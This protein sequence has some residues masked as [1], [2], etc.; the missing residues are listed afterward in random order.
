MHE[1]TWDRLIR[2]VA[3]PKGP[4]RVLLRIL[5][6]L[7][8]PVRLL[9]DAW[10]RR[11]P[12]DEMEETRDLM[13]ARVA[14]ALG[15]DHRLTLHAKVKHAQTLYRMGEY[16]MAEAKL[17]DVIARLASTTPD[18]P[19]LVNARGWRA[20]ALARLGRLPEA[21]A[22]LRWLRE[23]KARALGPDHPETL[24]YQNL[25]GAALYQTGRRD[26]ARREWDDVR[27]RKASA[28]LSGRVPRHVPKDGGSTI[29][30][31]DDQDVA[32][33]VDRDGKPGQT[34]D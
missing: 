6:I 15:H 30:R 14:H 29:I 3:Q 28:A 21:E 25:Y 33:L 16:E 8:T 2:T 7:L 34:G 17:A 11:Q 20:H 1:S 9:G 31:F 18:D 19:L 10:M 13:T 4:V 22:D 26:E 24:G 32:W 5:R 23:L 27:S 12:P